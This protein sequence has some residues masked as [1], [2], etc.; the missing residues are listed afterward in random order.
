MGNEIHRGLDRGLGAG[1]CVSAAD[2][3]IAPHRA[4][5][6]RDAGLRSCG[7]C[8]RVAGVGGWER[9]ECEGVAVWRSDPLWLVKQEERR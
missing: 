7:N 8:P 2:R 6:D 3:P 1:R 5:S 4:C 9:L